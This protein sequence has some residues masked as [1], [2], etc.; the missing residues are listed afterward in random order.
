MIEYVRRQGQPI[1]R[2]KGVF[3]VEVVQSVEQHVTVAALLHE[4][5]D[6]AWPPLRRFG[7]GDLNYDDGRPEALPVVAAQNFFLE[8]LDIDLQDVDVPGGRLGQDPGQGAD[9]HAARA[10]RVSVRGV[11]LSLRL[12]ASREAGAFDLIVGERLTS[13][14]RQHHVEVVVAWPQLLLQGKEA[15]TRLDV[16][17]VPAAFVESV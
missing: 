11:L 16:D 12:I 14:V 9:G 3:Q 15:L 6:V 7:I 13:G 2:W 5:A 17:A 1:R 4:A 10:R 8:A